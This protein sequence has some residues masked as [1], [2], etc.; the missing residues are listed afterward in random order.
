MPENWHNQF[1]G[2]KIHSGHCFRVSKTAL[3]DSIMCVANY[4][5]DIDDGIVLKD[6]YGATGRF[7]EAKRVIAKTWPIVHR[8][9]FGAGI[10]LALER[11]GALGPAIG[12]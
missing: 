1:V 4:A 2:L 3:T 5:I 12:G 10:V 9:R 11:A 6:R 7:D 8:R